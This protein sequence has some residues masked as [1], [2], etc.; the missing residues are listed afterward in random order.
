[1]ALGIVFDELATNA[2]K[3]GALSNEAGSVLIE[4]TKKSTAEG[5]RLP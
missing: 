2:A 3:Y 5:D 4:S 1:L